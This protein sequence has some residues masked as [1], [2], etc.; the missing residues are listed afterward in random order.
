VRHGHESGQVTLGGRRSGEVELAVYRHFAEADPLSRIVLE[1]MLA[2]V[3][4]R[5]YGRTSEPVG[6]EVEARGVSKSAISRTFIERT[7]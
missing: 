1:R 3:S 6:A 2:G 7:C 4:C 5:R